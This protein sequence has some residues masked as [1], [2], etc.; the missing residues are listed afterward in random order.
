MSEDPTEGIR[1]AM[2]AEI[3][4]KRAEREPLE[5]QHGQVWDT[6]E[7]QRDFEVTGFMAPFCGVTRKS[8]GK[9]GAVMFQHYPRYYFDFKPTGK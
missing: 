5:K 6:E 4:A 8:D 9:K 7:L 2:T 3:N 1:M